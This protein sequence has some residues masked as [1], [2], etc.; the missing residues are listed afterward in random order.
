[1]DCLELSKVLTNCFD[2]SMKILI[3]EREA[4]SR[5]LYDGQIGRSLREN[6]RV[7]LIVASQR[8]ESELKFDEG[9]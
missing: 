5:F 9:K 1:M 4:D 7:L 2:E 6:N 3:S 8:V